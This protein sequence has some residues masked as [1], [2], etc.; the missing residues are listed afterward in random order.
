VK[1]SKNTFIG[2]T[3]NI[4][5]SN[6]KAKNFLTD[7]I[8][9]IELSLYIQPYSKHNCQ[10]MRV[11]YTRQVVFI[12]HFKLNTCLIP[13]DKLANNVNNYF[14]SRGNLNYHMV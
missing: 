3:I 9:I 7:V 11:K 14:Q 10:E 6:G 13:V 4:A 2:Y 1:L 12:V 5:S 8:H